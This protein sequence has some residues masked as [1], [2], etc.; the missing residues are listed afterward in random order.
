VTTRSFGLS[1]RLVR[2]V[3]CHTSTISH[4]TA[5]QPAVG[6]T[7]YVPSRSPRM[8][9]KWHGKAIRS[10]IEIGGRQPGTRTDSPGVGPEARSATLRVSPSHAGPLRCRDRRKQTRF[11]SSPAICAAR[12]SLVV[13]GLAGPELASLPWFYRRARRHRRQYP[14]VLALDAPRRCGEPRAGVLKTGSRSCLEDAP[15]ETP[16]PHDWAL[17]RG[18]R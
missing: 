8:P 10:R 18:D 17:H 7:E 2:H 5:P 14:D 11:T 13:A 15:V 4:H 6:R 12:H 9:E 3:L 1:R 16:G